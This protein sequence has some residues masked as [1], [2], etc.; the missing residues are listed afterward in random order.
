MLS[1]A[2]NSYRNPELLKLCLQSVERALAVFPEPHEILV[3]DSA[4]EEATEMLM[5]E[6]FPTVRFFPHERNVGFG[7]LINTSLRESRGDIL[8]F[9]NSD[10]LLTETSLEPIVRHLRSHPEVGLMGL[11]QLNFNGSL[12]PTCLRFY[13]P[14]TIVYRRT[15][16]KFL[17]WAK[18]HLDWF[19]MK[20]FDHAAIK[21][22]D[23]VM[24]S[25][26]ATTREAAT[27]V[28]PMDQR[29]FMY[30]ED[31][32]WSRRFWE[33]GYKVIYF[34]ETSVY[35]YHAK[36][37]ARGGFF[38]SLLANRL[39]WFHIQSALKYFWKYRGKPMPVHAE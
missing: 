37:S 31:V 30:M 11:K 18:R 6:E 20:D 23:W 2:I 12:Q 26:L 35:H 4:T 27:R 24:G 21:E 28:G 16:L 14:M 7:V 29:F 10:I 19:T 8:L 36:G 13:R 3:V 34:P 32:D 1:I 33:A 9:L 22:V 38:R 5:R 17:P 25:A 15:W 39:T